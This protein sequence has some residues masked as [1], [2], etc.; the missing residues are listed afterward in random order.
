MTASEWGIEM[1]R[2]L[3]VSAASEFASL[4]AQVG[5][6]TV[7]GWRQQSSDVNLLVYRLRAALKAQAGKRSSALLKREAEYGQRITSFIAARYPEFVHDERP[8]PAA[9]ATVI[10]LH[11]VRG[12]E[13]EAAEY[14][15]PVRAAVARWDAENAELIETGA[16]A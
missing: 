16:A 6:R 8:H 13:L 15:Q 5:E 9:V 4:D 12:K 10:R 7:T 1:L 2:G 3:G 14:D 11:F